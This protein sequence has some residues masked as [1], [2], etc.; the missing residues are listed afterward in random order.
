MKPGLRLLAGCSAALLLLAVAATAAFGY[1]GQVAFQ[2]TVAGPGGTL[3]CDTNIIVTATILDAGGIPVDN[4]DVVWTFGA[5]KVAGDQIL[6]TPTMTNASGVA[7][8]TVKLACVAGN[9]TIVA[10]ADPAAAQ[11]VL[12]ISAG[13]LPPT[14]TDESNPVWPY[15]LAALGLLGAVL[16]VGRRVRQAL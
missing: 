16:I 14:G 8:T 12:A 5:G 7:S 2:V 11:T 4:R 10:T 9:R 1:Q 6:T 13:G 15:G 3:H